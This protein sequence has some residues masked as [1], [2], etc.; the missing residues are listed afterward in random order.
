MAI[1]SYIRE[2]EWFLEFAA[3]EGLTANDVALYVAIL[4]FVNRRAKGNVWPDDFIR[5]RNDRL[6]PYCHM[7]YDAM[8]RSRKKLKQ[9]GIID[10][11]N[12]ERSREAPAYRII[13]QCLDG[14]P[15]ND[16]FYPSETD[17]SSAD[18][19]SDIPAD[20]NSEDT[21]SDSSA[22]SNADSGADIIIDYTKGL[23]RDQ[24]NVDSHTDNMVTTT[25]AR[26]R[27][28]QEPGENRHPEPPV[29]AARAR[30]R[31]NDMYLDSAGRERPCRFDSAFLTSDRARMAVA[32]RILDR[33]EGESDCEDAHSLLTD[34]LHDGMPPE[35]LEDEIVRHTSLR[36]YVSAM[37]AIFHARRYEEKR[38]ALEMKRC[39]EVAKGNQKL[40]EYLYRQS[41]RYVPEAQEG[42]W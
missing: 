4:H 40:A 14:F 37:A 34:F 6:L 42:G 23:R 36:R 12:G 31:L 21:G 8:A 29:T 17:N 7:N 39:R 1:V 30:G 15:K 28:S 26:A 2:Q 25:R 24:N 3:D 19:G 22:D 11:I 9:M 20:N 13:Y 38:D 33:F 5:I 10:Y 18:D 16:G 32:Q 35:I 41:G 27:G